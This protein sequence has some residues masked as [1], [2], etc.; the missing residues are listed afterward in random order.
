M[1]LHT[2]KWDEMTR[3]TIFIKEVSTLVYKGS[4]KGAE[5]RMGRAEGNGNPHFSRIN[6][7][8]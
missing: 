4:P 6:Q 7:E 3:E 2:R 1:S 5:G 8:W